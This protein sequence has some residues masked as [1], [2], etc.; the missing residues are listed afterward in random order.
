MGHLLILWPIGGKWPVSDN[1]EI[2]NVSINMSSKNV[3]NM[4]IIV[5]SQINYIIIFDDN[6]TENIIRRVINQSI[7]LA[8]CY[9][10]GICLCYD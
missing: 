7:H 10:L 2:L 5:C 3:V 9:S 6:K 1:R 4:S 8:S